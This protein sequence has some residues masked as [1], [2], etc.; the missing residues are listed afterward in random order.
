VVNALAY[1]PPT[2]RLTA[3]PFS[4][5]TSEVGPGVIVDVAVEVGQ[6]VNGSDHIFA[7]ELADVY[8]G[9]KNL[10]RARSLTEELAREPP[11]VVPL[12]TAD[13]VRPAGSP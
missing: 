1:A 6:E 12:A 3:L 10:R 11:V 7:T 9:A 2:G 4:D 8:V 13:I 5:V